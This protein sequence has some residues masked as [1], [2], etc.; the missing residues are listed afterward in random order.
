MVALPHEKNMYIVTILL[1]VP[2]FWLQYFANTLEST[3]LSQGIYR[4][5]RSGC[6][7]SVTLYYLNFNNWLLVLECL[8]PCK[9]NRPPAGKS[10]VTIS[11]EQMNTCAQ[12]PTSLKQE[13]SN[14]IWKRGVSYLYPCNLNLVVSIPLCICNKFIEMNR[15][16]T[17][18]K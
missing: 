8:P 3:D 6:N 17:T 5:D 15:L 12:L 9:K 16:C 11:L 7:C 14:L 18:Y 1:N 13:N 2:D 10:H 4:G